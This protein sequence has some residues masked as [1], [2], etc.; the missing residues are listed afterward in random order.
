MDVAIS[1][2]MSKQE[3]IDINLVR[4]YLKVCKLSDIT[5]AAGNRI[6]ECA[7]R[8]HQFLDRRSILQYPRQLEPTTMQ[9]RV[10]R[11]LLRSML[12]PQAKLSQL[13]LVQPL[14]SWIAP[15]TMKWK[16][17]TWDANLYIQNVTHN[18]SLGQR[19][20]AIHFPHQP[21]LAN[22]LNIQMYDTRTPDWFAAQVPKQGYCPLISRV[23]TSLQS[24]VLQL[25]GQSFHYPPPP[26]S[27]GG[28]NFPQLRNVSSHLPPISQ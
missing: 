23:A 6:S 28:N 12:Q 1:L 3:L 24:M 26:S 7:W 4:I 21:S 18:I 10:W 15:S 27:N 9:R 25:N 19:C 16:Y 2:K 13:N 8:C 17:S 22:R 5:N 20:V 11:T 14:G